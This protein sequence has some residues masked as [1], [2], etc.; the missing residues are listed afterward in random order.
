MAFLNGPLNEEVYVNQ[1]DRFVDHDHLEKV[2]RLKKA[3]Y[4]IKQAPRV[5]YDELSTFL[6]SKGFTKG[7]I[8]PTL[9]M[10]RYGE[11]ILLMKIYVDDIIF[12]TSDPPILMRTDIVQAVC[13][14]A[15][16]QAKPTEKHLKE[17][18]KIFRYLKG[19]INIGLWY[20]KDSSFELTA[21]LDADHAGCL[22]TH[23]N[24]SRG[25]QFLGEK[26]VTVGGRKVDCGL[27]IDLDHLREVTKAE[28][29]DGVEIIIV[30]V[31]PP[32][33]D[34]DVPVVEPNKHDDAPVVD[35][36]NPPPPASESEPD[37]E[38]EVENPIEH[39]DETIPVSVYEVG[40]SSTTVIPRE[41]GDRLLPGFMRRDIDSL[42]GRMVNFSR[43]LCSHEMTHTLVKKK[44]E[45]MEKLVEK[46]ENVEEKTKCKKL[47]KEF[48][49]ARGFMFEECPNEAIDVSIKD[50]KSP[51]TETIMPPKS[52]P[53][54]QA[55]IRRMIKESV[56][57]AIAAERSRKA[58]DASGYGP[59]RSRDTAPAIREWFKKTESVFEISECAEGKKVKFAA[60][61]LEGPALTWWKTKVATMGLETMNQMPWTEMKQLMTAEFCLIEEIQRMEHELWNLKIKEYDIVSYTQRFNELALMCPRMVEPERVKVDAYIRGLTDNIKG[62]VTSSKPA[63]LNEA[64][65]LYKERVRVLE[66][67]NKDNNYLN[68]FLEA[69]ERA[70]RYY[71][72]AQSQFVRDRDIIG[73]L[74]K[75]RDKLELDVKEYKRQKE[76]YQKTQTI[77]N[78]TQRDKEE[79]YLDD[80]LQLQAKI[81]DLENV[82]SYAKIL[83][84]YRAYEL[85]DKNEQLHVFDY[86]E[87]LEDA[88][89]SQLKMDEFQKDEK[90]QELKIQ[91]IDY[92]KLNKLYDN[93]VPNKELSAKQTNF[94]SSCISSVSKI[95]SEEFSSKT[96]PSMTSM[97]S[98]NPML[99][100]FKKDVKEM[101]DV[102]VSVENDLDETFKQNELLKDRL[103]EASLAEDI[104]NLVITSCVE[105]RNKD[106]HDE[107][108]RISKESKDVSNESKTADTVCNDAFEVTQGLS[109]RIVELEKDLSKFEAKSIAFE[110]A[111]QHKSRENNSLKTV[112]KENE[113]FMASLQLENAHLKQTYKDLFESVQRSKVETNQCDEVKVKDN[114]DEIETKNIELEYRVASL[115]KENEHLKLTYKNLFDSIKK[116]RVQTKTSNVTQNEAENLK[117][118]LFEFAETKFSNILEKIEFFKKSPGEKQ[119]LFEN[120]TSVFQIK[121]DE[122]EKVLTQQ[123]KDFNAVKLELSNRTAKFE[124]YFEK[125]EKTKVVLERQLAR[126]VDDSKAEKD[127]FLKEIN[128][129]RT[130]LENLKGKSV[131]TKFDKHSILGKPPAD[132]LLINSQIS[133]SWFTPKVDMQKSLSKPV[134][135]QSLPK[136]EKDQLLKRIA[137][138][139]S[140]L[141]SQDIR[142]CQKEYHE[143]R[144]LYNALKVKFD[145]LNR[146]RRETNVSKSSKP[147]ESVSAKVHTGESSKPFSRRVS[148]FTTYSLQK[149]RKFSKNSQSFE[150]LTPQKGFKKRAS[151]AKHQSFETTYSCFTPVKQ[152]WRPIKESQTFEASTSQKSFKTRTL[153]GKNQVF[154]P[155]S[156]FTP[157]NQVWRPKQSHLK[158][159]KYSKSEM[160]LLQNKNDLA[161]KNKNN[162]RLSNAS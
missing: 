109:K 114:F 97:P 72:Q 66:G 143:L 132:K 129:L 7:T 105:I 110:I 27:L 130:Q 63:D 20:P 65:E 137:Y 18:K 156:R 6:M 117:S 92:G 64:L 108:D 139:E 51:L 79:K 60:A 8:D 119:H 10:I 5:W 37:N 12:R 158:T 48:K 153:K 131:K 46:L 148:Q 19:I 71:K 3:L 78:Q 70:K 126:K 133:K 43:R 75:Q 147:R 36:L 49:E 54:T 160:F 4:E 103:L 90:V 56:D 121:I 85:C 144:T 152:V 88:E 145:S 74:E 80:I 128:H 1:P 69:D 13:Y 135:A 89:K 112:Q 23:K 162:G 31:I 59:V 157:V 33:H 142:S 28:G 94:P 101:N 124:A 62:E 115:I 44:G 127:Q 82:V 104:K 136:N 57:A 17:V 99:N 91:P 150:T 32:D 67:I 141:A 53:M 26:L 86:E 76:E 81:K 155:H 113:N 93:F 38:I 9:F 102:F 120:K 140:K 11:D 138:L 161:L 40:E 107:I 15:R 41:D 47:K 87:T 73:D 50:E 122:L 55:A 83:K 154:D 149:D 98:A 42:F 96:K 29:N 159:F 151:N 146:K 84:L 111:L 30:N 118:Q 16:Y 106:L 68:E 21:F 95:S 22:D 24:T 134:T 100:R 52:A 58:N 123:T 14:C 25:I 34:H 39:E 35:P 61:T 77:F 125:L 45:A 2:Y 116:S